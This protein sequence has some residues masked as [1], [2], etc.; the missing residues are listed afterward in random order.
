MGKNTHTQMSFQ[1]LDE[2]VDEMSGSPTHT[3][4][5]VGSILIRYRFFNIAGEIKLHGTS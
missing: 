4:K 2:R 3:L 5:D 1:H